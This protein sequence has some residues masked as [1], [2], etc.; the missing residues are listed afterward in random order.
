MITWTA[1]AC[2]A[3]AA[4][5]WGPAL[6]CQ[7]PGPAPLKVA[8]DLQ[9][10]CDCRAVPRSALCLPLTSAHSRSSPS[11]PT[12]A[13]RGCNGCQATPRT[14]P[15]HSAHIRSTVQQAIQRRNAHARAAAAAAAARPPRLPSKSTSMQWQASMSD[16]A[17]RGICPDGS[18]DVLAGGPH[19]C[20]CSTVVCRA[21]VPLPAGSAASS[22]AA[23]PSTPRCHHCSVDIRPPGRRTAPLLSGC[24][25]TGR[26]GLVRPHKATKLPSAR[27]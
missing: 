8:T 6:A 15:L 11:E 27:S 18:C 5:V 23:W 10:Q 9:R 12:V 7:L 2:A 20:G 13:T 17:A 21:K 14:S 3:G 22:A 26:Q 25:Q 19:L 24:W 4:H 1:W 16:K